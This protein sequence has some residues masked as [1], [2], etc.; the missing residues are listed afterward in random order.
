M[1]I[2]KF[3][4]PF[5]LRLL[6]VAVSA[7]WISTAAAQ[8]TPSTQAVNNPDEALDRAIANEARLIKKL[9][10][11]EPV[12]E[13]YI[14]Q[15]QR[16]EDL[17]SIPKTDN[18]FLGK[19]D[20]SAQVTDDS[21][22]PAPGFFQRSIGVFT[23]FFSPEFLPRGFAQMV[24]M[25]EDGFDHNHYTFQ[26]VRREF[27]GDVRTLVY[28]VFPQKSAGHGRFIGRIW[29]EDQDYNV[30]RFNGTYGPSS[31]RTRYT[32][33]DSWR[34]NCGPNLWL[35]S[36]VYTE[37][38]SMPVNSGIR[39]V[40]FKAQTRLWSYQSK[41]E[42]RTEEFTNMTVDT[43]Q[44]VNDKSDQASDTSP[45][46]AQRLWERQ[47]EDNILERLQDAGLIA[48]PGDVD[49]I[50]T[51]V[52]TNLEITNNVSVTP[53]MRARVM[54]TTPM[55][56]VYVGHTILVSRGL[57]DVLPDEA[58]LAAVIAHEFAHVLLGHQLDT[59]YA[60]T[61][62]LFFRDDQTLQRMDLA[63]T[64]REE[65]AAD[66]KAIEMLK[67]SPYADKL[68]KAGLFL[69]MLSARGDELP[70]LIRPLIGNRMAASGKDLRM[71]D[72]MDLAP[73]LEVDRIDQ[74]S[75]LP[76]GSR[77][78]MDPWNDHLSLM[79]TRNVAL[80]S[81]REKYPFE[82]TPFMLHLTRESDANSNEG[83]AN[84]GPSSPSGQ[85]PASQVDSGAQPAAAARAAR[86]TAPP[87]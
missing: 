73:P 24:V 16:D 15:M 8:E 28:D 22:I 65:D 45:V 47:A 81:P 43:S 82:I 55:E 14:Q 79:K 61:D 9:K 54:L 53:E 63:R 58:T 86:N 34:V 30:V 76:L 51:T 80:L 62:R 10:T 75:A 59:K 2:S 68:P 4:R 48:P 29:V 25:D 36:Y 50:L 38:G 26:Y 19:L 31:M 21:F 11:M 60:F 77:V 40:A 3:S 7:A 64:E 39:H 46:E 78:R 67:K 84:G 41:K 83:A 74:V 17:G 20:L 32:H 35:P 69:K 1:L 87:R 37:E 66:E 72:L 71:A 12:V 44:G 49:K 27:L 18:Y 57:L 33:F 70:H 85:A 52:L 42:R 5:I 23:H 6:S 13:T 56:S